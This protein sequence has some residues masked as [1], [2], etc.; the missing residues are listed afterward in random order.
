[1]I[2]SATKEMKETENRENMAA[3]NI[4]LKLMLLLILTGWG[5]SGLW[6]VRTFHLLNN[7]NQEVAV[8]QGSATVLPDYMT[9]SL[10]TDFRYYASAQA[11]EKIKT[12]N[13]TFRFDRQSPSVTLTATN[14]S[15]AKGEQTTLT[16]LTA[17]DITNYTLNIVDKSGNIAMTATI[18]NPGSPAQPDPLPDAYRSPFAEN[19]HYYLT[20]EDAK[21]NYTANALDNTDA[22]TDATIYVG[23]DVKTSEFNSSK[24]FTI[25][26]DSHNKYMHA[27]YRTVQSHVYNQ[28]W[29]MRNQKRDREDG[30]TGITATTLAVI[31]TSHALGI[32]LK[33]QRLF[34]WMGINSRSLLYG[35]DHVQQVCQKVNEMKTM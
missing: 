35:L 32:Y 13:K 27:M 30:N 12:E 33:M 34:A 10:V 18:A 7:S 24:K 5:S 11:A 19:Y 9:S 15:P 17:T 31:D 14:A 23:Y 22:W 20:A 8:W 28:L 25:Y 16:A 1:M 3:K 21:N 26:N 4:M 2:I 6:A 29:N